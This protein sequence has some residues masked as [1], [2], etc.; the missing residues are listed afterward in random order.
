MIRSIVAA[1]IALSLIGTASPQSIPFPGPGGV[2]SGGVTPI[3]TP[4][5]SSVAGCINTGTISQPQT[6][7]QNLP[8]GALG[9]VAVVSSGVVSSNNVT[10]VTD[11]TN[12]YT[13]AAQQQGSGSSDAEL[14]YVANAAAVSSG[15]NF[16][17]SYSGTTNGL[18]LASAFVTGILT[19]TPLDKTALGPGTATT[20]PSAATGTLT[21]SNEVIFGV[22]FGGGSAMSNAPGFTSLTP[23]Q[24]NSTNSNAFMNFA[25][26]VVASTG[27]VTYAPTQAS[28]NNTSLL[29]ASFEGN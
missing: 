17:V 13:R 24:T 25:Y 19:V 6:Y 29:V 18:C 10:G 16:T 5:V 11:G 28:A 9:L 8:A 20:S 21:K 23:L 7:T 27:S 26:Q 4:T 3:G 12:S 2:V 15:T 14:W 22:F 1:L